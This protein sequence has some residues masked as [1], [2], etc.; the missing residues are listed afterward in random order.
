MKYKN[1]YMNLQRKWKSIFPGRYRYN[2]KLGLA[3]L[4]DSLLSIE[5]ACSWHQFHNMAYDSE[6]KLENSR[7][8]AAILT[9]ESYYT[10]ILTLWRDLSM[11]LTGYFATLESALEVLDRYKSWNN[12]EKIRNSLDHCF[13]PRVWCVLAEM[14]ICLHNDVIFVHIMT[15][16]DRHSFRI[17]D[18]M[19][20]DSTVSGSFPT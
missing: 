13:A 5:I 19:C 12:I 3:S 15:S 9:K 1:L 18:S 14:V 8:L 6:G 10:R 11:T 17:N 4:N 16:W 7:P 2:D 20:V